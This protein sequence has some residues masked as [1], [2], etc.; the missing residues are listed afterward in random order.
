ML[1]RAAGTPSTDNNNKKNDYFKCV[2]RRCSYPPGASHYLVPKGLGFLNV[3]CE[4]IQHIYFLV[5]LSR[6]IRTSAP[7]NDGGGVVRVSADKGAK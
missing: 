3:L 6:P 7:T 1:P 2:T 4:T 5:W